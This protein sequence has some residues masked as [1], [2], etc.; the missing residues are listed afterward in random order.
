MQLYFKKRFPE[1][2]WQSSDLELIH[3]N[4]ISTWI[5]PEGLNLK[6]PQHLV[7][8]VEKTPYEIPS[9]LKFLLQGI[10]YINMNF[11]ASWNCSK[12]LS[13]RLENC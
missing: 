7:I 6:M 9:Y 12:S 2:T 8:D 5:D 10:I 1:I 11:I 4:S 13:K 3:R